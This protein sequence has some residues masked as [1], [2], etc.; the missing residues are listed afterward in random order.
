ME[1]L[2]D[3]MAAHDDPSKREEARRFTKRLE[4]AEVAEDCSKFENIMAWGKA[5]LARKLQDLVTADANLPVPL[6]INLALRELRELGEKIVTQ[7]GSVEEFFRAALP[8]DTSLV[9]DE[10]RGQ[11]HMDRAR[12]RMVRGNVG[13]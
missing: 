10:A 11:S 4:L 8:W 6:A 7:N 3:D 9:D 5:D 12:V 2:R 1:K 13:D